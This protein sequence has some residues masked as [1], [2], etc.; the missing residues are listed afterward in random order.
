MKKV[1]KRQKDR[2]KNNRKITD[3][4]PSFLKVIHFTSSI[5]GAE[6]FFSYIVIIIIGQ[7]MQR[8]NKKCRCPPVNPTELGKRKQNS[9]AREKTEKIH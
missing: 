6:A 7:G 4:N 8:E 5:E 1:T 2:K 3:P 9:H